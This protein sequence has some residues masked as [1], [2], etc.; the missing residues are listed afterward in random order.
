MEI[1]LDQIVI[2]ARRPAELVRFWAGLVGGTAVDRAHGWSH[3][4]PPSLPKLSFQPVPEERS[5]KNR[6]HLDLLVDDIPAAVSAALAL[7]ATADGGPVTDEVG[8]FQV[9]ADPEAN[10]FCFVADLVRN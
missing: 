3:V 6:L 7:G 8:T 1:R 10:A 5:G 4:E 2:D 9:M